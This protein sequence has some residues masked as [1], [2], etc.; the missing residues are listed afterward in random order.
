MD[1]RGLAVFRNSF[2]VL[3]AACV[4]VQSACQ[5]PAATPPA[6]AAVSP[7]PAADSAPAIQLADGTWR[8]H[9]TR[10][11]GSRF[12]GE[13]LVRLTSTGGQLSGTL[14]HARNT[15]IP[16]QNL[17]LMPDGSFSGTTPASMSGSRRA[18]PSKVTGQFS[19]DTVSLTFDSELC[20]P[21]QGTATRRALGG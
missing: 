13:W 7:M 17:E 4:S 20:P 10:V 5:Y 6:P 8:V 12:C 3:V 21:R 1:R 16:I 14:S 15:A 11:P 18:P 9:G 2:L 19:R